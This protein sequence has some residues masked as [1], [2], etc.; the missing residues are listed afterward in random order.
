M[1]N[2]AD[3]TSD[4]SAG[5]LSKQKPPPEFWAHFNAQNVNAPAQTQGPGPAMQR[6]VRPRATQSQGQG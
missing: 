2:P 4:H 1:P 3:V 5:K 6:A